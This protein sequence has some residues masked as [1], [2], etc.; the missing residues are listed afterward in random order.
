LPKGKWLD[1]WT[2]EIVEG[3]IDSSTYLPIYIREGSIIPLSEGDMIVYGNGKIDFD[4]VTIQSNGNIIF[5]KPFFVR[6]LII[7][8]SASKVIV[9]GKEFSFSKKGKSIIININKEIKEIK[10]I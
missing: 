3:W 1:Y 4:G 7:V 10:M 6:N 2:G 8:S 5:S 9:D